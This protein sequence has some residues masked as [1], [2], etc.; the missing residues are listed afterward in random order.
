MVEYTHFNALMQFTNAD[1]V[2]QTMQ[3]WRVAD[4]D[5]TFLAQCAFMQ[6]GRQENYFTANRPVS[7]FESDR[8][9]FLGDNEYGSWANP[10]SLQRAELSNTEAL[11]GD[12][13]G[14]LLI[15]LGHLKPEATTRV[16]TQLGQAPSVTDALPAIHAYRDEE[17]VDAA[18]VA[19]LRF[20]GDYLATIQV[21]TPDASLNS[22]LNVH[23]PRQC[24]TTKHWSRYL[25]LYQLG[26]GSRGIGFRDSAQDVLG[27]LAHMP[28]EARDLITLLLH[29]QKRDGSALHQLNPLTMEGQVGDAHENPERPQYYSDDHL[30]AVLAVCGYLKE[31]GDF[32]YLDTIVPY[33]E[34]D[35]D[36]QPLE[37]GTVLDHL[38]R[39]IDFTR[40]NVG[41]HGLPLLGY[42]DWNDTI[43][44]PAGAESLFTANLYGKALRE[45]IGLSAQLGNVEDAATFRA[46]Y[47]EMKERVNAEAWDGAW[48]VR[49]FDAAGQPLGSQANPTGQ[50]FTNGQSWPVIS[51]FAPEDRARQ[52]L[53]SVHARLD[54]RH[55]IKLSTPGFN[56]FDPAVGGVSTYPPGAK[57]NGGIFLHANPWVII[58]ETLV[59]NGE[60]A[61]AYYDQ[62]NPAAKNDTADAYE[63]EPYVYPQNI[64]GDEHPQFGLA[65]NSWLSG[66]AAW[67]YQAGTQYLLGVRAEYDGLRV[68]P[69][70]PPAWDGFRMTRAFRGATYVIDVTNPDHVSQ[71][72]R[73]VTV[74]GT[75]I[76]GSLIPAFSDGAHHS[77]EVVMG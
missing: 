22:M 63:C 54:T 19:L 32:A 26:L 42:A 64:L 73:A 67:M 43:N 70:L 29:I 72:V 66:T 44:L 9:V 48:Y 46:Y 49:Y 14:A 7:S 20:W 27:V 34:K 31:T 40:G 10:L 13:I 36:G 77:V 33:Y 28:Q 41:A 24:H 12:N 58:A 71:G 61:F 45:L 57:E 35:R 2:P 3:S 60:R 59:G 16:I 74:D 4:G 6:R 51:G 17:A 75:P 23:N 39:G 76:A 50:I 62:I 21:E 52:A 69:C 11:R 68:D 5:Q 55:G 37:A 18:F 8:K 47:E 56:G 15:H 30:W 1:W 25:S 38:R 65:R 53:D